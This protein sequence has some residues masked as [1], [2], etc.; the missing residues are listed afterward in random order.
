VKVLHVITGLN[1]GGAETAL[2]RLL[3]ALPQPEFDHAVVALGSEGALSARVA[4]STTPCHLGMRPG[5]FAPS[6]VKRLRHVIRASRPDV[7][8]GWMYHANLMAALATWGLRIPMIWGV[9]QTLYNTDREKRAT[10]MVIRANAAFSR[11]PR[12]IVYNSSVSSLQHQK[13]GFAS[14]RTRIIPNGYDTNAF[15][16]DPQARASV[17]RELN[18]PIGALA[19]GLVARTHP[20]KDHDNF[21]RAAALFVQ[22]NPRAVFVLVGDGTEIESF[23]LHDLARQLAVGEHMRLC[24][25]RDDIAAVNGALDIASSSSAWGDAFS[26]A[27]AEAMA[28]GVPCVATDVGDAREIVGDTGTVVAPRDPAAL[29]EGWAKLAAL[30][31]EERRLLGARARARIIERYTLASIARQYADLYA[32]VAVYNSKC[33]E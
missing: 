29:A 10:R 11:R 22:S 2:C 23:R 24:G 6:D 15:K 14:V 1:T 13:R 16:P 20:M 30:D 21:L 5:R 12:W 27:I 25:R 32:S 18:I 28:C 9:R 26:N 31:V 4:K 8:H 7:I 17:R 3:E 19:I 33:A